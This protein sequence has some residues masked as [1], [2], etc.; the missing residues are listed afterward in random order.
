MPSVD[1]TQYDLITNILAQG[2]QNPQPYVPFTGD[3]LAAYNAVGTLWQVA[4]ARSQYWDLTFDL[5]T[6]DALLTPPHYPGDSS[7]FTLEIWKK[8]CNTL[9]D[10]IAQVGNVRTLYANFATFNTAVFVNEQA[11]LDLIQTGLQLAD[12]SQATL[13]P[14]MLA[15]GIFYAVFSA[16]GPEGA[17]IANVVSA[18]WNTSL[19]ANTWNPAQQLDV[20]YQNILATMKASWK[21]VSDTATAQ[22]T[23]ILQDWGMT[24]AVSAL[25][26]NQLATNPTQAQQAQNV[27]EAQFCATVMQMMMPTTC[28]ITATVY[29][30]GSPPAETTNSWVFGAGDQSWCE[31]QLMMNVDNY[32][33]PVP[34][35]MLENYVWPAGVSR[36]DIFLSQNG[37]QLPYANFTING[38]WGSFATDDDSALL[39]FLINNSSV[40][41][42]VQAAPTNSGQTT[43]VPTS[44]TLNQGD[45]VMFAA[46]DPAG[47]S[48][49]FGIWFS[50][51]GGGS[52]ASCTV[53][54]T[55]GTL[56]G[57][58]VSVTNPNWVDGFSFTTVTANANWGTGARGAPGIA[59]LTIVN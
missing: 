48:L 11:S 33:T 1:F 49:D 34:S 3:A 42:L 7:G 50:G 45:S 58:L 14:G 2:A 59:V 12:T 43:F 31:F 13:W 27:G 41:L 16:L 28:A 52:V 40:D 55:V 19:A 29:G 6:H 9:Q 18:A 30:T 44:A 47:P 5:T 26:G 46:A 17:F 38:W 22:E 10:E 56:R 25:C 51:Y 24:Q 15:E 36:Q 54:E 4:D 23:T 53:S 35:D 8:V 39:I 57:G 32:S 37:W 20:E 21:A